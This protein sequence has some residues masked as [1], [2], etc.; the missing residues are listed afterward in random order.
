MPKLRFFAAIWIALGLLGW[1]SAVAADKQDPR[2]W[3]MKMVE[4][5]ERLNYHGTLV[6]MHGGE[7][8]I[9]RMV[10]RVDNGSISERITALDGPGREIIRDDDEVTCILPDQGAVMVEPRDSRDRSQN[11]L[12][13]SLPRLEDFDDRYYHLSFLGDG[14]VVGRKTRVLAV[15]PKDGYR[16]GYRLWLDERTALPLKTQLLDDAGD[17]LEQIL[18]TEITLTDSIAAKEVQPS[19][20]MDSFTVQRSSDASRRDSTGEGNAAWQ[21]SDLPAGFALIAVR[22]KLAEGAKRPMEQLVFSDG[23]AYVSVFIEADV[24]QDEQTEG[25]SSMGAANA[26]TVMREGYLVT[27]VGEVPARTVELIATSATPAP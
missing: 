6:H 1:G 14:S 26:Y 19:L 3:L 16:Y 2:F 15:R 4:S 27:A 10:H 11:P 9:L 25:L 18:F 5:V 21:I 17:I 23:L 13:A 20:V 12:H 8:N 7:A 24:G 22:A